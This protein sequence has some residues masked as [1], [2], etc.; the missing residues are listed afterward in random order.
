MDGGIDSDSLRIGTAEREEANR[1]LADHFA[2]GRLTTAEYEDRMGRALTARTRGD[3]RPLFA[4]LP[5]PHP[6]FLGPPPDTAMVPSQTATAEV[7]QKEQSDRSAVTAGIL[8]I[9]LPFG[10]G[11]FYTGETRLAVLQL[12]CVVLTLGLGALW[13]IVDG[14]ILLVEGGTDGKGRSLQ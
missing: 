11:R 8:Q 6:V 12:A 13:P 14:I 1:L 9:A 7:G 4:D 10:T 3:V 2:E 5:A